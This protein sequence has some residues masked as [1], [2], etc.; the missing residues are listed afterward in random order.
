MSVAIYISLWLY[1]V[2][3]LGADSRLQAGPLILLAPYIFKTQ[4]FPA[5]CSLAGRGRSPTGCSR[6]VNTDMA[7]I[8]EANCYTHSPG[9]GSTYLVMAKEL[10]A[11][12][13]S[14]CSH[15]PGSLQV[16][17]KMFPEHLLGAVRLME[18]E[19]HQFQLRVG[20]QCSLIGQDSDELLPIL[21]LREGPWLYPQ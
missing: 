14:S 17:M 3:C 10:G 2:M 6:V 21:C 9:L 8:D 15:S 4:C 12:S 18:P 1:E 20:R 19:S 16:P 7:H 13:L 5:P 11:S